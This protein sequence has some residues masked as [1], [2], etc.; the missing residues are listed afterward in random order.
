MIFYIAMMELHKRIVKT[1]LFIDRNF[2]QTI[3]LD[4]LSAEACVS[5]FHFI[6]AFKKT[7]NK[8][9]HQYLGQKRMDKAKEMLKAGKLSIY[10][11]CLRVG[12]E[13][14]QTFTSKFRQHTGLTPAGYR[15]EELER[16]L[17]GQTE[18]AQMIPFCFLSRMVL[19]EDDTE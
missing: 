17:I 7:Y 4:T 15:R 2:A 11:V 6:R 8:T 5:K 10:E 3:D 19:G 13:S 14:R 16:K 9:P 18:P 12:F 1:K